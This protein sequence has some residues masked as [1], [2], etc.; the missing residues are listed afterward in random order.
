MNCVGCAEIITSEICE[1]CINDK[2]ITIADYILKTKCKFTEKD[3]ITNNFHK[4]KINVGYFDITKYLISEVIV[5]GEGLTKNFPD[6]HKKRKAF[7]KYKAEIEQYKLDQVEIEKQRIVLTD[8]VY[9][10]LEKYNIQ[11]IDLIKKF[12]KEKVN[13][14]L[15]IEH[16]DIFISAIEIA[17]IANKY[18]LIEEELKQKKEKKFN[19]LIY[20]YKLEF[21]QEMFIMYMNDKIS[22]Y[23]IEVK[24]KEQSKIN[25]RKRKLKAFIKSL[26]NTELIKLCEYNKEI[27]LYIKN[28]GSYDKIKK[29]I[30]E[31]DN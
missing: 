9:S 25:S 11:N 6:N 17:Y 24:Y 14:Y 13:Q 29:I 28:G 5:L 10:I 27:K 4:Y 26:E 2:N 12:I 8:N 3:L 30:I 23:N 16:L 18:Y 21:D 22:I 15:K 7:L 20:K 19:D 1:K 31:L